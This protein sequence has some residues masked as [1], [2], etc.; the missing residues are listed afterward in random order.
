MYTYGTVN[1]IVVKMQPDSTN[2]KNDPRTLAKRLS[3]EMCTPLEGKRE[4]EKLNT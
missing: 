4:N 1:S 2:I 3:Y